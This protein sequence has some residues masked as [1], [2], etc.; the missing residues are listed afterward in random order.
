MLVRLR[1]A[2]PPRKQSTEKHPANKSA[3]VRPP[4]DPADLLR[5]S[6][7]SSAAKQLTE[8]PDCEV[9][10]RRHLEEKREKEDWKQN[11]EPCC[12]KKQQIRAE[13]ACDCAGGAYRRNRGIR[14]GEQVRRAGDHAADQI[15][16]RKPR[17]PHPV[18]DVVAENPERPHVCDDVE[19]AAVQKL[20]SEKRPVV[21]EGK[22]DTGG[23]IR[24]GAT[25]GNDPEQIKNLLDRLLRKH[26]LKEKDQ[27]V[28]KNQRVRNDRH[29]A[30]RDGVFNWE[31]ASSLISW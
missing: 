13:H 4:C 28:D 19:P 21:V 22:T 17:R 27:E 23:P 12:W 20:G 8:E 1:W 10:D 11:N 16:N 18:L 15:K 5:T 31:H 29:G 3:N 6:Q 9:K 26:Q 14:I 24:V 30:A 2:T 25:R 7:C